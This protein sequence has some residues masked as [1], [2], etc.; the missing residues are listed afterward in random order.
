MRPILL[1][2]GLL[3][4][5]LTFGGLYVLMNS[6]ESTIYKYTAICC[7]SVGFFLGGYIVGYLEKEKNVRRVK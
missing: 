2:S 6:N 1:L 3:F 5:I 4:F 7:V